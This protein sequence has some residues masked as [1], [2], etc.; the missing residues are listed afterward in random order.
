VVGGIIVIT[1]EEVAL[2][3]EIVGGDGID[4]SVAMARLF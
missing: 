4:V 1:N 3:T 2:A